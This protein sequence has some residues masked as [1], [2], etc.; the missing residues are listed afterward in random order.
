[1][2]T[3]QEMQAALERLAELL[4][5][6]SSAESTIKGSVSSLGDVHQMLDTRRL[7]QY[8]DVDAVVDY[9]EKVVIPQL[10]GIHDTLG[11]SADAHFSRVRTASEQASRLAVRVQAVNDASSGG[12]LG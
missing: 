2:I 10:N 1:M 9:V 8:K 3:F 5:A 11:V 6:A 12:L 7:R 4:K